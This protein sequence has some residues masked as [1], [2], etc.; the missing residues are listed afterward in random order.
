MRL[1]LW[2]SVTLVTLPVAEWCHGCQPVRIQIS[3]TLMWH[4]DERTTSPSFQ[5]RKVTV[6]TVKQRVQKCAQRLGDGT[7]GSVEDDKILR[8]IRKVASECIVFLRNEGDVL[9]FNPQ[10]LRKSRSFG[11]NAKTIVLSAGDSTALKPSYF[12]TAYDGLWAHLN[13]QGVEWRWLIAKEPEVRFL[14]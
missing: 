7:D 12:V 3:L 11:Q 6:T 14:S 2:R 8:V 10:M 1:N 13:K 5:A 4:N 9:L